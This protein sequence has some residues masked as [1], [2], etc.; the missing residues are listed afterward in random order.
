[1]AYRIRSIVTFLPFDECNLCQNQCHEQN[2]N[3][4]RMHGIVSLMLFVHLLMLQS[5]K[6]CSNFFIKNVIKANVLIFIPWH[7]AYLSFSSTVSSSKL[8][9]T[10]DKSFDYLISYYLSNWHSIAWFISNRLIHL[11]RIDWQMEIHGKKLYL[12]KLVLFRC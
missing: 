1:M 7:L 4:F 2:D 12:F 3:H 9:N 6:M 8:C 5:I 11:I 10:I